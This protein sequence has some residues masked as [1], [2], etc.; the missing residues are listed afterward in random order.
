MKVLLHIGVWKTGSSAIQIFLGRNRDALRERGLIWP[1]HAVRRDGHNAIVHSLRENDDARLDRLLGAARAE[2]R[3]RRDATVVVSSEHLWPLDRRR[4]KRLAG[5][6]AGDEVKVLAYIR[7]QEE[8]WAS[9]YAQQAKAYRIT[10]DT[11]LWG[12][13]SFLGKR[14]VEHGLYFGATMNGFRRIFGEIDVRRYDRRRLAGGDA[15]VDFLGAAGLDDL[16]GLDLSRSEANPSFGWKGVGFAMWCAE[17]L[18]QRGLTGRERLLKKRLLASTVKEMAATTGDTA[19]M[20]KAPVY[21]DNDDRAAIRA[22]YAADEALLSARFFGGAPV[23]PDLKSV[24]PAPFGPQALPPE[25]LETAQDLFR[26]RLSRN[27]A[28]RLLDAVRVRLPKPRRGG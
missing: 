8:M 5:K 21:L 16:S 23:W 18:N 25:E 10:E 28:L 3:G 26:A 24:E 7:P 12:D 22:H 6:L 13:A 15:V 17:A 14:L 1:A 9:L 11:P 19:W 4:L 2:A 20:G 27:R